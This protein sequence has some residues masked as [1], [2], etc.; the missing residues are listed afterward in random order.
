MEGLIKV[1]GSYVGTVDFEV[2]ESGDYFVSFACLKK[3]EVKG[4][5]FEFEV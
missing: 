1:S 5:F 3:F 2:E 4:E